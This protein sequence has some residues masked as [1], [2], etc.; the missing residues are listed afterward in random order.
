M[1][2]VRVF[3][4]VYM[5]VCN[6]VYMRT[7]TYYMYVVHVVHVVHVVQLNILAAFNKQESRN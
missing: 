6:C 5:Y 1:N 3:T 4:S 2:A 7:R